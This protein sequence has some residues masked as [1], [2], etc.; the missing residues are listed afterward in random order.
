[1]IEPKDHN[2]PPQYQV[3]PQLV[4]DEIVEKMRLVRRARFRL[5]TSEADRIPSQDAV[6]HQGPRA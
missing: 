2:T 1:M 6:V 5:A 3:D 4:A